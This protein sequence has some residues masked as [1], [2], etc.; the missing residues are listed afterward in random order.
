MATVTGFTAARMLDIENASVVDGNIVG[1]DL[2]LTRFDAST[3]NAGN[4][5]GAT[6]APGITLAEFNDHLPIGTMV[7]YIEATAPN[8]KWL[9]IVGQTIVGGQTTY[10][11]LWAK[12]PASMKSGS[13]IVFPDTRGRVS[14][15]YNSGDALFD[16]IGEIGGSKDAI[17]VAH[18]HAA[19]TVA[20]KEIVVGTTAKFLPSSGVV[21]AEKLMAWGDFSS[22]THSS[23]R[24]LSVDL[25][26]IGS[27]GTNANIQPY[28]T[29][30][31]IIKA[32]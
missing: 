20:L 19:V 22:D 9:T 32:L 6:G 31:K 27:S 26:S 12:L 30:L 25:P 10:A 8:S 5:R 3:I 15:N 24:N 1:D 13:N 16:T 29:T 21:A 7:D 4:V 23:A 28:F 11:A 14:V 17:I 18:D 2:I